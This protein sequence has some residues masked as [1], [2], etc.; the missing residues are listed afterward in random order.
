MK[1]K[2]DLALARTKANPIVLASLPVGEA[3]SLCILTALC[4][5]GIPFKVLSAWIARVYQRRGD[6]LWQAPVLSQQELINELLDL[7]HQQWRGANTWPGTV[8][9]VGRYFRRWQGRWQVWLSMSAQEREKDLQKELFGIGSKSQ[10]KNRL[11]WIQYWLG[12]PSPAGLGLLPEPL[13]QDHIL[14]W[15]EGLVELDRELRRNFNETFERDLLPLEQMQ[16]WTHRCKRIWTE[17]EMIWIPHAMLVRT[18]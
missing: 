4:Y 12:A 11:R 10:T 5:H 8:W 13:L 14:P 16:K 17:E 1:N 3:I 7:E 9:T 18:L 15:T 6:Q 2:L